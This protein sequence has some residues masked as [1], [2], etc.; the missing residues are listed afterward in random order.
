MYG[1]GLKMASM[2]SSWIISTKAVKL[3]KG[4]NWEVPSPK[5]NSLGRGSCRFQGTYTSTVLRPAACHGVG[6]YLLGFS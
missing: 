2:S 1:P 3:R 6:L 4:E 5:S